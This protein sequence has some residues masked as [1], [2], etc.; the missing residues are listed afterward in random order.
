MM[1][2]EGVED[3]DD[4][5]QE[6][7]HHNYLFY[8]NDGMVA[9]LGPQWIQGAFI[10]LVGLFNRMGLRTNSGKIVGIV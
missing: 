9:S 1:V 2:L 8:A 10:T 6:G 5:G 3:P 4:C 7:R